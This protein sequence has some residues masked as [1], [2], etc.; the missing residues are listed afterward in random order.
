MRA[1]KL[2]LLI[3]LLIPI[4]TWGFGFNVTLNTSQLEQLMQLTFPYDVVVNKT[5]LKLENPRAKLDPNNQSILLTLDATSQNTPHPIQAE[6]L[7]SGKLIY[8]T[9]KDQLRVEN[10]RLISFRKIKGND[11]AFTRLSKDIKPQLEKMMPGA[12]FL[13]YQ[14]LGFPKGMIDQVKITQLGVNISMS[15]K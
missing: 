3:T 7:L 9:R 2:A 8:D 14:Q 4:T 11:T 1:L 15:L 5:P 6:A 12:L 13:D 10:P